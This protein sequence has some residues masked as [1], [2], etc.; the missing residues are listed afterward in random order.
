MSFYSKNVFTNEENNAWT[1][2]YNLIEPNSRILDIGC[3]SG[4]WGKFIIA[5]KNAYVVGVD[6]DQKDIQIAKKNLDQAF[7]KNIE[8]DNLDNFGLFDY[9]V[10]ADI[11]EHLLYPEE[12]LVRIKKLLKPSGQIIFSIP[13]MANGLVRIELLKGRF[14]Y[15]DWGLL[16]KTHLHYYDKIE[17]YQLFERAG[18]K[19]EKTDC[20]MRDIPKNILKKELGN[21]GLEY[22]EKFDKY[23]YSPESVIFQYIGVAIPNKK[24]DKNI[25]PISNTP[26]DSINKHLID[27]EKN[28]KEHLSKVDNELALEKKL[29]LEKEND[30]NK[31]LNSRSWKLLN[32]INKITNR[33]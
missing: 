10:M 30:L 25:K 4:R 5:K 27:I 28:F 26:I 11:I 13:N 2:I 12:T 31:I 9:I 14:E 6:I 32:K 8:K 3:S 23:I 18:Y 22:T 29:H 24:F 15:T 33:K 1:K 21:I 19:I 16:D 17:I 20:T 7:I